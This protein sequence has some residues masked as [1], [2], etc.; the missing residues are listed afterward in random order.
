MSGHNK[1]HHKGRDTDNYLR[2]GEIPENPI[3]INWREIIVSKVWVDTIDDPNVNQKH[4]KKK[5]KQPEKA[6]VETIIAKQV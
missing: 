1:T 3:Y 5:R 6:K 4:K 2:V